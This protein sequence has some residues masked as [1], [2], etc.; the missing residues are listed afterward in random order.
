MWPRE[1]S[2]G[3][4]AS[5]RFISRFAARGT[6]GPSRIVPARR[7]RVTES[8]RCL[9]RTR[10]KARRKQPNSKRWKSVHRG[11]AEQAVTL[12]ARGMPGSRRVRGDCQY[13]CASYH[14][15]T[16]P[17]HAFALRYPAP[18]SLIPR[19]RPDQPRAGSL[20][21]AME[22]PPARNSITSRK[23]RARKR[24]AYPGMGRQVPA[25]HPVKSWKKYFR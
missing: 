25:C 9:R 22:T 2:C 6:G 13:P 12:E 23:R 11:T 4:E 18:P 10:P 3:L 14:S 15:H 5:V 8:G 1:P 19:G 21:P 7:L 16:E 24:F 17:E 20:A